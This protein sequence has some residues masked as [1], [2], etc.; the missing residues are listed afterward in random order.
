MSPKLRQEKHRS[1]KFRTRKRRDNVESGVS[2]IMPLS[3]LRVRRR[4]FLS[5]LYFPAG[6]FEQLAE[7]A[8]LEY[9]P[10]PHAEQ[11]FELS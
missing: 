3:C 10:E 7:A 9:L 5:H 11:S 1:C 4:F 2:T 8:A 6:Q